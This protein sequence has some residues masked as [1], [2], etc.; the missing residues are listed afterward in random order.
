MTVRMLIVFLFLSVFS[1][2][3]E[4]LAPIKNSIHNEEFATVSV[5]LNS[6]EIE[7]GISLEIKS[8]KQYFMFGM[9]PTRDVYCKS[10]KIKPGINVIEIIY[11]DQSEKQVKKS[12]EIFRYSILYKASEEPPPKFE[13]KFFHTRQNEDRCSKCHD[14]KSLPEDVIPES[15]GCY[16]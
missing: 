16:S 12:V 7:N 5:K 3:F 10:I 9:D 8:G 2:G 6:K 14:M 13:E 11:T 4:I 1:Y 15:P